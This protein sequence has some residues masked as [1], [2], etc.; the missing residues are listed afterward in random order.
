MDSREKTKSVRSCSMSLTGCGSLASG[1]A[2]PF[3]W[4][5]CRGDIV[6]VLIALVVS[7]VTRER[8]M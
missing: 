5:H 4:S 6:E 2:P 7:T 1:V 3:H 8:G